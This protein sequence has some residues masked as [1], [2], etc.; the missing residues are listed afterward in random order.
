MHNYISNRTKR[1]GWFVYLRQWENERFKTST[2]SGVY[3]AIK[4]YCSDGKRDYPLSIRDICKRTKVSRGWISTVIK[5]LIRLGMIEIVGKKTRVGGSVDIFHIKCASSKTL[6][7][8]K[9]SSEQT[10][11]S[12]ESVHSQEKSVHPVAESVQSLAVKPRLDNKINKI[13]KSS[14]KSSLSL[15]LEEFNKN[16]GTQYRETDKRK[17]LLKQRL[18]RYTLAEILSAVLKM[19][20]NPFYQGDNDSNWRADPDHI[21]KSDEQIDKFLNMKE[22]ITEGRIDARTFDYS[23][24]EK[25]KVA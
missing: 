3:L 9:V 7:D 25:G 4:S 8:E 16:F 24:I 11:T 22:K 12:Q 19:S 1:T 23:K 5:E 14:D 15:F 2:Q 18:K 21:L 17:A 10:L 20:Q 13:N 6:K